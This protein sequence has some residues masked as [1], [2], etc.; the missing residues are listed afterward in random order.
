MNKSV[1]YIFYSV[2]LV[3]LAVLA[4]YNF[5]YREI[6]RIAGRFFSPYL[7]L[8][9]IVD[10]KIADQSL[11]LLSREELA[12]KIEDLQEDNRKMALQ[13]T[14]TESLYLEN[15][16]LRRLAKLPDSTFWNCMTGE[17]IVRDPY[18]WNGHFTVNRGSS[19][20]VRPGSAVIDLDAA[21]QPVLIGAVNSV[22]ENSCVVVTVLNPAFRCSFRTGKSGSIGYINAGEH[23]AENGKIA[24]DYLA[25][26]NDIK[27]DD[28]LVTTGF[29][30]MIPSGLKI[31]TIANLNKI[32]KLYSAELYHFGDALP[33]ADFNLL[34]FVI[35]V[36]R[37]GAER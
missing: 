10:R 20:G 22:D 2:F 29:E 28:I 14:L 32:D 11:L 24:L 12:Q 36:I 37:H 1:K 23:R 30:Q 4:T 5:A 33:A 15:Q 9:N 27:P 34:K 17:V 31:G 6:G 25:G 19:D 3:L 7:R 21:G 18:F 26:D 16:R 13:R 35:I 8:N